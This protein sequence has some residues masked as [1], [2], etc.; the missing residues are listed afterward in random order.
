VTDPGLIGGTLGGYAVEALLGSGG[1][2]SVY[3]GQ[4]LH[5]QRPVA[6][7]VL[8][9]HAAALPGFADRFRQEARLV[10]SLRH[11]NIV[12][13][14]AFG[15]ERGLT[16][17]VQELL[18]GPTLDQ[19][20]AG[21]AR[22]GSFLAPGEVV[23]I[24][25]QLAAALDAA[26]AAGIIHRDVKPAN[27]MWNAAGALVL[28]DFGIAKDL[29]GAIAQT[30]AGIVM[31]TPIY[32]AP[33]QAQGQPL[34]P[35][36]DVYALGVILYELL[37]NRAPF[38]GAQSLAVLLQHVQ[39]APPPPR[40][41]RPEIRPAVEAVVL[42]ALA[43]DPAARYPRAG[44]MAQSLQQAWAPAA[45]AA[46]IHQLATR[47]WTPVSVTP[48]AAPPPAARPTPAPAPVVPQPAARPSPLLPILGVLLLLAFAGAIALAL[49]GGPQEA[50]TTAPTPNAPAEAQAS[51]PVAAVQELLA[52]GVRDGRAGPQGE[53]LLGTLD[54]T[55]QALDQGDVA[56]ATA[57]LAALQRA[58]LQEARAGTLAPDLL[59]RAL[60]GID[61]IAE[62]RQLTLPLS[63]GAD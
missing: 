36:T 37:T 11:P 51:G 22:A 14:Y 58:L 28:T 40:G 44:A 61:A 10:A 38:E 21:A 52:D 42:R 41:L 59:R 53:A 26:H 62:D 6:I 25:A 4:D 24:V 48:P 50:A 29:G 8:S 47:P 54:A 17:M 45:A 34:S 3:R 27:A 63:V 46:D 35:A 5:L 32:M 31:G 12:Q 2:A 13:I 9:D 33:E 30:Q 57:Q 39:D 15:E 7:K 20:L 18:P 43:K 16:Y 49:R 55:R 60:S 23:G 19:R 1:M 56:G